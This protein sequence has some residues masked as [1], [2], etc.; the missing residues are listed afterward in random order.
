MDADLEMQVGRFCTVQCS[1]SPQLLPPFA[2]TPAQGYPKHSLQNS[3]KN[4]APILLPV[5]TRVINQINF[6]DFYP[7][8]Y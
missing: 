6:S 3:Q 8:C 7:L 1:L 4:L 2:R 5:A